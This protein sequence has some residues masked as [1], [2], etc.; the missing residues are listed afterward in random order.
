MSDL[1]RTL[2]GR[3][4][5]LVDFGGETEDAGRSGGEA[6]RRGSPSPSCGIVVVGP[7]GDH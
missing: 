4:G 3:G 2:C 7:F 1:L 6:A 5:C